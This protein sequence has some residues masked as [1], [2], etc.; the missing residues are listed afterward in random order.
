MKKFREAGRPREI[1]NPVNVPVKLSEPDRAWLALNS[2]MSAAIR[3]LIIAARGCDRSPGGWISP[4]PMDGP[5]TVTVR[6]TAS[7]RDW[8]AESGN[9]SAAIRGLI[10]W[11][12]GNAQ[13]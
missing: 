2:N 12:R 13:K 4:R 9:V 6:M 5:K 3:G 1:E 8:L 11:G 10:D 7:D